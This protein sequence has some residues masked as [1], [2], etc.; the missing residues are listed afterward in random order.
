MRQP[1]KSGSSREIA[2][3]LGLQWG[4]EGKGK[5]VDLLAARADVVVRCQ[6]GSN[7]GHTVKV[8]GETF[9]TH[10]LPSGVL[11]AGTRNYVAHGVVIDPEQFAAEVEEFRRRGSRVTPE[12]LFVSDRAHVVF[13]YHK[14]VDQGREAAQG[15]KKI[16]T[17][18]RG[19]GPVY[20]DKMRRVGLRVADLFEDEMLDDLLAAGV[21][22]ANSTLAGLGASERFSPDEMR[23]W[24]LQWRDGLRPFVTDTFARLRA[25]VE[26]GARII[27]EGAQGALLDTD[28][29]AYPYVTSSNTTLAGVSAGTGIRGGEIGRV[30][31]VAKAYATR[32]GAGPFPSELSGAL[33]DAIRERGRE[34][35]ST[36]GR[37]RRCGWLDAVAL[38]YAI[39][40]NGVTEIV[41]T[42]PDVLT[43]QERVGICVAYD[44]DGRRVT[45]FPASRSAQMRLRPVIEFVPGWKDHLASNGPYERLP[46]EF[47]EYVARLE[48]L[49]GAPV[50]IIS[51]GAEREETI[52]RAAGAR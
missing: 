48:R 23:R 7:A 50:T 29:G 9:I 6:G 40:I 12:N 38:R 30:L 27:L 35:G 42:K 47:Q 25:E 37:P 18:G 21:I 19:I 44:L 41:L 8:G 46:A 13:P 36:T 11:H 33:G 2:A 51:V 15:E 49:C 1:G 10:M 5:V 45:D 28:Y 24:A 32:V 31:G 43:G 14:R 39:A 22:E 16:G 3:I 4:D 34:Y 17:T 20:A 26:G 52:F